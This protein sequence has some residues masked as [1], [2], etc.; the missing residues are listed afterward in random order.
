[1]KKIYFVQMMLLMLLGLGWSAAASAYDFKV[2]NEDGV[3]IYYN[4]V[5]DNAAIVTSGYFASNEDTRYSGNIVIPSTVLRDGQSMPVIGIGGY[6][7]ANCYDLTS[8][9]IP[10]TIT[11]I[12]NSA[13]S[14]CI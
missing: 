14:T 2:E 8:I 1:M 7:F 12:G 13:F 6:A 10:N 11:S 9:V 5:N 3:T 4:V